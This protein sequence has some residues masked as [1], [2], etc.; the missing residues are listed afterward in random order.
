MMEIKETRDIADVLECVPFE[1]RIRAKHRDT[2]PIKEMLCAVSNSFDH[3]PLFKFFIAR[4]EGRI[5]GYLVFKVRNENPDRN[6]SVMRVYC[7]FEHPELKD[8]FL[9]ILKAYGKQL[10]ITRLVT[11]VNEC[12]M[13][14]Y[15]Q[16]KWG[17][18]VLYTVL[19]RR[20]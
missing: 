6:I 7:D 4:H 5:V 16:K 15:L 9:D 14:K 8:A 12:R 17:C 11:V 13:I 10:K 1:C 19:E 2:M 18:R 3:D 20:L